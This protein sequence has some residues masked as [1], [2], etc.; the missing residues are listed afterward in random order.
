[1]FLKKKKKEI[2]FYDEELE[3]KLW[4]CRKAFDQYSTLL[5]FGEISQ[6][7]YETRI[8]PYLRMLHEEEVRHNIA[9]GYQVDWLKEI[10]DTKY[11]AQVHSAI[12]EVMNEDDKD[13]V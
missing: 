9:A 11:N 12:D 2:L 6:I 3:Q 8:A 5:N 1:M 4:V 13:P 7:E 10:F